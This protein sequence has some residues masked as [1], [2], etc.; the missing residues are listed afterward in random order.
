MTC[1]TI[2]HS[3]LRVDA[4]LIATFSQ[5]FLFAFKKF[6]RSRSLIVRHIYFSETN[7]STGRE[8]GFEAFFAF[9]LAPFVAARFTGVGVPCILFFSPQKNFRHEVL[10]RFGRPLLL[11]AGAFGATG[12]GGADASTGAI[13]RGSMIDFW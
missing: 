2:R 12:P 10:F 13:S 7:L 8:L 3:V 5:L 6:W 4:T 11:M 1:M 9:D